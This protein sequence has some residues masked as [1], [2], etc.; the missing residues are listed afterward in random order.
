MTTVSNADVNAFAD[1]FTSNNATLEDPSIFNRLIGRV[2]LYSDEKPH[3]GLAL[4]RHVD[5]DNP[6]QPLRKPTVFFTGGDGLQQLL[7]ANANG[8]TLPQASL[9]SVMIALGMTRV[10]MD[11]ELNELGHKFALIVLPA[12]SARALP[13]TW[14]GILAAVQQYY[15]ELQ[16]YVEKYGSQVRAS[17]KGEDYDIATDPEFQQRYGSID[18]VERAQIMAHPTIFLTPL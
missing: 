7:A 3:H 10:W 11:H 16:P 6:Q 18:T 4:S 17:R 8:T 5:L 13:A 15:P 1:A 2:F 12:K 14:D 9:Y